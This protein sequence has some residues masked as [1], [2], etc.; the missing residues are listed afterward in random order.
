MAAIATPLNPDD[1][2]T[3]APNTLRHQ[4]GKALILAHRESTDL[5]QTALTEAGFECE[6]LRQADKPEYQTY[7]SIYRC[8]LNHSR[9][10]EFAAQAQQPT[11][12]V[13]ADFVPVVGLGKLPLPF[14]PTQAK[15]GNVGMAW[16]YTCAPQLYSVTADGFAEG[17]STAL[18][19]YIL[20]PQGAKALQGFVAEITT[21]HGTGY[22]N[23]DSEI[24]GFLRAQK[25]KN[26]IPFRNYGEHG[27]RANPEHRRNGM[28]GLHRADVL[29]HRL[30]FAPDYAEEPH[31]RLQLWGARLQAR[32]KGIA[33]L[34]MGKYLR[35]KIVK[36]SKHPGRLIRFAIWR[37]LKL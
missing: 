10:W 4:V 19:A 11:L 14:S 22:Y 27:G 15:L 23:F 32:L 13:E 5:L 12:I 34:A 7:A 1:K 30:K 33:R 24:D 18:V 36:G 16:L 20:T 17:F 26:Y 25:L 2:P 21:R 37:Q 9:A 6:V 31:S 28:S 8:L 35:P 3:T 29:W